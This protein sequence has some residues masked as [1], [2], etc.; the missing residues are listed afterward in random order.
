[1]LSYCRKDGSLR[2]EGHPMNRMEWFKD[3]PRKF[4]AWDIDSMYVRDQIPLSAGAEVRILTADGLTAEAEVRR[5]IGH[6]SLTQRI[7]IEAGSEQVFFDTDVSW[8]E[9]HR[10]LKVRFESDILVQNAIH[11]MQFG[12]VERPAHRSS[13]Y[14]RTRFEVCNHHYTALCDRGRGFAV[15][16]DSKYGVSA[17]D[18]AVC[19]TLLRAGA[20]P[21]MRSDQ[22]EH[23]FTY[24]FTAWTGDFSASPA[25][26]QGYELN[27]PLAAAAGCVPAFSAFSADAPDIILETVKE[28]ED[29][30]GD[31]I[32]RLYECMQASARCR[33]HIS[34][35][36][37]R[38][39]SCDMLEAVQREIS[40]AG[41]EIPLS[42]RPFEIK[43]SRI[44]KPEA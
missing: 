27:Q 29:G 5:T 22:G 8:H 10:L 6:S 28:A 18:G 16:N 15:L 2:F 17:Q 12:F 32:L 31:L 13:A 35:P 23:H 26:R 34:L 3:V 19:L 40:P 33:L 14:D 4:D 20:S 43:T 38:V 1:M 30:S 39:Y 7:R 42:F 24:A 25:V 41:Q 9:L 44:T 21:E 11:E 36:F 37:G